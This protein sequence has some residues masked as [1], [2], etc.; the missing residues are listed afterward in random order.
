MKSLP[1]I[2]RTTL[3]LSLSLLAL[4]GQLPKADAQSC[5]YFWH[6]GAGGG[7]SGYADT[8]ANA[9][10]AD[11]SF[12]NSLNM[13]DGKGQCPFGQGGPPGFIH[14]WSCADGGPV[15]PGSEQHQ[16]LCSATGYQPVTVNGVCS[17]Q[18]ITLTGGGG[19]F[20][21]SCTPIYFIKGD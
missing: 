7:A 15:G 12:M 19:T 21:P 18:A 13:S 4:F 20:Q 14:D 1:C 10:L 3:K 11:A 5:P 16:V 9:L 2:L 17:D 6:N 8:A